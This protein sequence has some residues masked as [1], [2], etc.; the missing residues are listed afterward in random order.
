MR[1]RPT[2]RAVL[3]D[4][5]G[6]MLDT[7]PIYR[8]AGLRAADELGFALTD[9][10]YFQLVGRTQVDSERLLLETFGLGFP[11]DEFRTRWP[12]YWHAHVRE[13]GIAHKPGLLELIDEIRRS[14]LLAAVA[15]SSDLG[16]AR[17]TL[18]AGGLADVFDIVV[19]GDQ[20]PNGKPAPD[21]YLLAAR[22][23]GV[24][25]SACVAL[26]DSDNGLMAA[27]DAG[28]TA[29]M[30]P[31]MKPPSAPAARAAYRVLDSLHD[32]REV[33]AELLES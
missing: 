7:E 31:D 29:L 1:R 21:I 16:Q 17:V 25:P 9:D 20:V 15:T 6:L 3:F 11:L 10:I 24:E 4:M 22:R 5:D 19:T 8:Q 30:V 18:A 13:H 27:V 12:R 14:G 28:T 23:V 2:P 26:E 32:A 33:I